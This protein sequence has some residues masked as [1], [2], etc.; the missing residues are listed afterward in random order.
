M[1]WK[2]GAAIAAL[3]LISVLVA[4]GCGGGGT[5]TSVGEAPAEIP[6]G[7]GVA[8]VAWEA[9]ANNV[10]GT[11]LT[12]LAGYKI[13]YGLSSG[14][15]AAT[16]DVG[17]ATAYSVTDLGPGT[18]FIAVTAYNGDGVESAHSEEVSKTIL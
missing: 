6:S 17:P 13:Y 1:A 11:P 4:V 14:S 12:D 8:S 7:T 15:Y 16:V 5:S 3:I 9:P 10:D 2:N 18:Y